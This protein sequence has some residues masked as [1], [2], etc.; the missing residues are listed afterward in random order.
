MKYAKIIEKQKFQGTA[1]ALLGFFWVLLNAVP[2]D[3][4]VLKRR[5]GTRAAA[6]PNCEILEPL[7]Q[8]LDTILENRR[9]ARSFY[10]GCRAKVD[11]FVQSYGASWVLAPYFP[12]ACQEFAEASHEDFSWSGSPENGGCGYVYNEARSMKYTTL[13]IVDQKMPDHSVSR[14]LFPNPEYCGSCGL[15]NDAD[16]PYAFAAYTTYAA[17]F[18][19]GENPT[20]LYPLLFHYESIV[21]RNQQDGDLDIATYDGGIDPICQMQANGCRWAAE[22]FLLM[23]EA[24]RFAEARYCQIGDGHLVGV[25][26]AE[27]A[28]A[29]A[30]AEMDRLTCTYE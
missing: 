19:Q 13:Q 28:L 15:S 21:Y 23:K 12:D 16:G 30:Q 14:R 17:A 7:V 9:L 1:L 2:S 27:Q 11:E 20:M 8:G 5:N 4:Q 29:N 22:D 24:I 26:F 10:R 18:L 25:E 3:A 6:T